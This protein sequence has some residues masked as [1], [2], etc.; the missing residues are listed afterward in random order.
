MKS[1]KT[2]Y[3]T[4]IASPTREIIQ[5]SP[6]K[7]LSDKML[8]RLW[9]KKFLTEIYRNLP[10]FSFEALQKRSSLVSR[11]SAVHIFS[12]NPCRNMSVC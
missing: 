3:E 9:N 4:Q 12:L 1:C 10:T 11:D 5:P 6:N 8:L 2:F 7:P